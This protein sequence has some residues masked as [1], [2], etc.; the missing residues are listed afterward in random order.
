[1]NLWVQKGGALAV[2]DTVMLRQH[3]QAKHPHI[4]FKVVTFGMPKVRAWF[5]TRFSDSRD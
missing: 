1:M 4:K 5:S 3:L 2:L